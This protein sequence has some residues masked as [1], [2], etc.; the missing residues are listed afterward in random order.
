MSCLSHQLSYLHCLLCPSCVLS[1]ASTTAAS[2]TPPQAGTDSV[3]GVRSDGLRGTRVRSGNVGHLLATQSP[4]FFKKF[5]VIVSLCELERFATPQQIRDPECGDS[6]E[7]RSLG[8]LS[9]PG[10]PWGLVRILLTLYCPLPSRLSCSLL[11]DHL[12]EL[13]ARKPVRGRAAGFFLALLETRESWRRARRLLVWVWD[14]IL[15]NFLCLATF[16]TTALDTHTCSHT[17]THVHTRT[18]T[19]TFSSRRRGER[20]ELGAVPH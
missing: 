10:T 2:A 5:P 1:G 18:R 3:S 11:H 13:F 4:I 12:E 7:Q 9:P 20:A 16:R 15:S 6:R 8:V 17:R 19:R 14:I